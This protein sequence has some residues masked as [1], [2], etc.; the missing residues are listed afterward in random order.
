MAEFVYAKHA[1]IE[2]LAYVSRTA[3]KKL[4]GWEEVKPDEK[5][6]APK[7]KTARATTK[8]SD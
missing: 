7:N 8:S 4:E 2:G 1:G 6:A 3:L 5:D